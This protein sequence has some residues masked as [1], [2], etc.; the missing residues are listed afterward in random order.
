MAH[1][2]VDFDATLAA[3]AGDDLALLEELRAAFVES[4]EHQIDLLRRSRCDGNWEVAAQR[5]KSLGSSFRAPE[6]VELAE[7]ALTGAPGEPAVI[8]KLTALCDR[9]AARRAH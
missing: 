8:R 2:A 5:L 6:L 9:F 4:M 7:N 1:E 3:A